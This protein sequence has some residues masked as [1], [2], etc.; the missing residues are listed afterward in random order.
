MLHLKCK[1]FCFQVCNW[2]SKP[3][4]T[5][6]QFLIVNKFLRTATL[7]QMKILT[8]QKK[9]CLLEGRKLGED[10]DSKCAAICLDKLGR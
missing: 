3:F 9:N 4:V 7:K 1:L 10:P 2:G 5:Q 6:I 8:L